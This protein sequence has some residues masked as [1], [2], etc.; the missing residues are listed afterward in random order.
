MSALWE[1]GGP[2]TEVS[3]LSSRTQITYVILH[4]F[5]FVYLPLYQLYYYWVRLP[6]SAKDPGGG[7][8]AQYAVQKRNRSTAKLARSQ[9]K[10]SAIQSA[11]SQKPLLITQCI[12][13]TT[14]ANKYTDPGYH[15]CKAIAS[16]LTGS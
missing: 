13:Y 4:S 15:M 2:G 11:R 9:F 1:V 14:G 3:I 7:W 16:I 8:R 5:S 12:G 6:S 10:I